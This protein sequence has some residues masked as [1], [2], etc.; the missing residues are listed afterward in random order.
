MKKYLHFFFLI[1]VMAVSQTQIGQKIEGDTS[2][3]AFGR[4]VSISDNG[5]IIAVAGDH[6]NAFT[7][8]VRVFENL[9]GTWS[10]LGTDILGSAGFDRLGRS[11]A[12]SS[13]GSIIAVASPTNNN[14]NG[15]SAG[16][17]QVF[18]YLSG[19]WVQVGSDILGI[20][21]LDSFG[22]SLDISANGNIIAVGS[23]T[24]SGNGPD[25][26]QVRVYQNTQGSWVQI[27][28]NINGLQ[29]GDGF[30]VSL[31]LSDSG[32]ILAIGANPLSS[33]GGPT[34][35]SIV[36]QN[37]AGNW[38]QLGQIINGTGPNY[39]SGFSTALSSDGTTVA[40]GAPNENGSG[41]AR[42]YEN[43]A[44]TWTQIGSEINGESVLDNNG[45]KLSLSSDGT[46]LALAAVLNDGN[47]ASA[48]HVRIFKNVSNSWVQIGTD[49]EGDQ[50]GDLL[51]S[52]VALSASGF[53][54]IVGAAASANGN[55]NKGYAK[56][57]DLSGVLSTKKINAVNFNVYPNPSTDVLNIELDDNLILENITLYNNLGQKVKSVKTSV[58]DVSN[59]AKGLY[60]IEV[61]TNLGKA[62][63]KVIIR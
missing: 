25:S 22:V 38:T 29:P 41:T 8:H 44:G 37:V 54:L 23:A 53:E 40:I 24:H 15:S 56:V 51:G 60:F 59:L 28:Q 14:A 3:D 5:S 61:T 48:G 33:A 57:Y 27:G 11:I 58:I 30:G 52:D 21:Q 45:N 47:G 55:L 34:G 1:P 10:Q 46:I 49:I 35:Y 18:Q 19:N 62:D 17:V 20:A 4:R 31:S 16:K 36:F 39:L 7:G 50:A 6:H 13:D 63:Q 32:D 42:V 9:S 26:G 43:I 12:L 2:N